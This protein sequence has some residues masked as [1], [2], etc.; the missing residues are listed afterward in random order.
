MMGNEIMTKQIFNEFTDEQ[1]AQH[2]RDEYAVETPLEN[3]NGIV[4]YKIEDLAELNALR[5]YVEK[6]LESIVDG[7][8]V[9]S[10]EIA[11]VG[12]PTSLTDYDPKFGINEL[13]TYFYE[14]DGDFRDNY[15]SLLKKVKK[16]IFAEDCYYQDTPTLRI[17]T[18]FPVGQECFYPHYHT[19]IC[20]GHHPREINIWIPLTYFKSDSG[21][22]MLDLDASREV[23]GEFNYDI[24]KVNANKENFNEMCKKHS[25]E[26]TTNFGEVLVFDG[27][28]VHSTEKMKDQTRVSIDTRL[29]TDNVWENSEYIYRGTGR[30]AMLFTPG[31]YYSQ[32]RI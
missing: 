15:L 7:F 13:T 12:I 10:L 26:V 19:D 17:H 27:R 5:T 3:K 9:E 2:L 16:N 22:Y 14:N 20:L 21:F 32:D 29:L 4:T 30:R 25:S 23:L 11:H 28:C 8:K 1:R 6:K 31:E 18:P 24:V